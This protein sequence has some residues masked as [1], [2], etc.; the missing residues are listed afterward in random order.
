MSKENIKMKKTK[1][2]FNSNN[3]IIYVI[4]DFNSHSIVSARETKYCRKQIIMILKIFI[5]LH[6]HSRNM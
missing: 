5:T 3:Y 4:Y 1:Y 6:F 2:D